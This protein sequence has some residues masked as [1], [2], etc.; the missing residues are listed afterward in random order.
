M[1]NTNTRRLDQAV[2]IGGLHSS[3]LYNLRGSVLQAMNKADAAE[4]TNGNGVAEASVGSTDK[5]ETGQTSRRGS[6]TEFVDARSADRMKQAENAEETRKKDQAFVERYD[7]RV[8][9]VRS[10]PAFSVGLMHSEVISHDR[11][12]QML[13]HVQLT[14]STHVTACLLV[15]RLE[16]SLFVDV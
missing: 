12:R 3:F 4:G 13:D 7:E 5:G 2:V 16:T 15:A 11:E 8:K 1:Q 6:G 10:I 9:A 14:L